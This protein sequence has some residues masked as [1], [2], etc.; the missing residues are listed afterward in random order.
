M[1]QKVSGTQW[2]KKDVADSYHWAACRQ[3]TVK[4]TCRN[5]RLHTHSTMQYCLFLEVAPDIVLRQ[6]TKSVL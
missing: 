5:Q 6:H 4:V 3:Q 2:H 1:T